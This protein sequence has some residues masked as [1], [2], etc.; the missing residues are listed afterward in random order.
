MKLKKKYLLII[1]Y[2]VFIL[3]VLYFIIINNQK[4]G[5]TIITD[6]TVK[7][8]SNLYG[9]D[10]SEYIEED[11]YKIKNIVNHSLNIGK[12]GDMI[13]TLRISEKASLIEL[14]ETENE[15]IYKIPNL[16]IENNTNLILAKSNEQKWS[17]RGS[18]ND[19]LLEFDVILKEGEVI[20]DENLQGLE[21]TMWIDDIC[22]KN[23]SELI[24]FGNNKYR[25][26]FWGEANKEYYFSIMNNTGKDIILANGK[27]IIPEY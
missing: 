5:I 17:K 13:I 15:L 18:E 9:K 20:T 8:Y 23:E 24:S 27:M 10:L 26:T 11:H 2:I 25:K 1:F 12:R 19:F 3:F 14:K 7:E 16:I 6:K 4:S 21:F 22:Y